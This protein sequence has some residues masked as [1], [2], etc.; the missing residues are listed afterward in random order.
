MRGLDRLAVLLL[1]IAIATVAI[2]DF[3]A[4]GERRPAPQREA[5]S[6][7]TLPAPTTA[8]PTI[9]IEATAKQGNATGTAFAVDNSGT[10]L[11]ARHVIESCGRV[12][13]QTGPRRGLEAIDVIEHPTAD[14]AVIL[15]RRGA[16]PLRLSQHLD[17]GQEGFHFGFPRGKPGEAH[18]QLLGRARLKTV[19]ARRHVE[20]IV[21]WAELRRNPSSLDAL[22][23]MSGGPALNANGDVV[24]VTIA[25]SRR[26]GRVFTAAPV[27]IRETLRTANRSEAV[28]T[29]S[30]ST[31]SLNGADFPRL[32]DALR[33]ALTVAKVICLVQ[34]RKR[35]PTY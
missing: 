6:A 20:P 3:S 25:T 5:Q 9:V 22:S 15:T 2:R 16:P 35:R 31:E 34:T 23:G 12:L 18:S 13:I 10:W 27:S 26:R 24:G 28:A 1:L 29:R 32:G 4:P 30:T 7:G 14:V 33:N 11:T 8:D 19:G 21:A 17:T